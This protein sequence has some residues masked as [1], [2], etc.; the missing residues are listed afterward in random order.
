LQRIF[1]RLVATRRSATFD[2]Y[3]FW[4]ALVLRLIAY[5]SLPLKLFGW[6]QVGEMIEASAAHRPPPRAFF[7]TNAGCPFVNGPYIYAG[8]VTPDNY[9]RIGGDTTYARKVPEGEDGVG[10]KLTLF[11]CTMRSQQKWWFLSEA[12]EE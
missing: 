11:R 5:N 7:V 4:R 12:D 10:K 9:A 8:D 3:Q 6:E 2:F 1:D